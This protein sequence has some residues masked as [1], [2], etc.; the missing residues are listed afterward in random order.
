MLPE[1][2]GEVRELERALMNP[3]LN[4]RDAVVVAERASGSVLLRARL[5]RT[6]QEALADVG[7]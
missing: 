1:V 3:V 6:V 7:A 4:A 5:L 2:A